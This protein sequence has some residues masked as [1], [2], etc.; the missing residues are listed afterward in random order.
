VSVTLLPPD[1][2]RLSKLLGEIERR[3][4]RL[5]RRITGRAASVDQ[6][7]AIVFSFA[8]ALSAATSP[9]IRVWR[10]GIL[11]VL[12]VSLGTAGSTA[13]VLAVKRNGI[14]VG[15][16]TV[17]AGWSVYNAELSARFSAD[18]DALAL[19]VITAGTGAAEMTAEARFT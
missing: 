16:V 4:E 13:T 17:P 3:L 2:R 6:S 19:A 1:V 10:G 5:E 9:P 8:G 18:S 7:H 15:T 12:A 11:S 14:T